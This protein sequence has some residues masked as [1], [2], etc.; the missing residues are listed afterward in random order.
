MT[1]PSTARA[2]RKPLLFAGVVAAITMCTLTPVF[3]ASPAALPVAAH[4]L[5][6]ETRHSIDTAID[7][8][9]ADGRAP[10]VIFGLWIPS[11]GSYVT[12]RGLA[13]PATNTPM[14]TNMVAPIARSQRPSPQP[15]S[16]NLSTRGS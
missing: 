12:A 14:R 11:Q 7:K 9:I 13:D 4:G 8:T 10:G 6:L 3:G 1:S 16:S 5:P 2:A 15:W